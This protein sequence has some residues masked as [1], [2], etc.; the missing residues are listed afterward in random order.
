MKFIR[1]Y[2]CGI[3]SM[4]KI[5][6]IFYFLV[7]LLRSQEYKLSA[8]YNQSWVCN[9]IMEVNASKKFQQVYCLILA[10]VSLALAQIFLRQFTNISL[11]Q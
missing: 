2:A 4:I 7:S 6:I 8:Q 11:Q 5:N 9:F 3:A 10:V 1:V